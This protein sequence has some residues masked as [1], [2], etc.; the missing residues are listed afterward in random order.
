M[1]KSR[2]AEM[3][4][5]NDAAQPGDLQAERPEWEPLVR[6]AKKTLSTVGLGDPPGLSGGAVWMNHYMISSTGYVKWR[7]YYRSARRNNGIMIGTFIT[8]YLPD[9]SY[10]QQT[11]PLETHGK[12]VTINQNAKRPS[13]RARQV[14]VLIDAAG[15][16][17]PVPVEVWNAQFA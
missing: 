16:P 3:R 1:A 15:L 13:P 11:K 7:L 6:Q 17:V 8:D 4:E 5:A 2:T 14:R 9:P 10:R 12:T